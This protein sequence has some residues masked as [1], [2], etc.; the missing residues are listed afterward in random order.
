M[1]IGEKKAQQIR[2]QV[3]KGQITKKQGAMKLFGNLIKYKR[4]KPLPASNR[5]LLQSLIDEG[6]ISKKGRVLK[7]PKY[8]TF[9]RLER[10]AKRK[11][12]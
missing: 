7:S 8:T 1:A 12:K 3:R 10:K 4:A 2:E 6:Y 5:R 11:K 9:R